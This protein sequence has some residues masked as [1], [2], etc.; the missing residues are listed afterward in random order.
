MRTNQL[1]Q[2]KTEWWFFDYVRGIFQRSASW[3]LMET[4]KPTA[5]ILLSEIAHTLLLCN[6]PMGINKVSKKSIIPSAIPTLAQ[7]PLCPQGNCPQS[8][9]KNKMKKRRFS[10]ATEPQTAEWEAP[11]GCGEQT[12]SMLVYSACVSGCINCCTTKSILM[13]GLK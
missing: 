8:N 5:F 6:F 10:R 7:Y 2:K 13:M 12:A 3:T 11:I 9:L 4:D 1:T